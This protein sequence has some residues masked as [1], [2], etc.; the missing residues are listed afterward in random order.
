ME[1]RPEF[2]ATF[3]PTLGFIVPETEAIHAAEE[4]YRAL[5]VSFLEIREKSKSR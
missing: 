2:G 1:L 3:M 5:I 4:V